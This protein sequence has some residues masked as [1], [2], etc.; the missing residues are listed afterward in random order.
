MRSPSR[1]AAVLASIALAWPVPGAGTRAE[2]GKPSKAADSKPVCR[3]CGGT[4]GL[5]PICVCEPGTKKKPKTSYSMRCEPVCVPAPSPWHGGGGLRH[6]PSCTG[7]PCD[8]GC[9]GAT[10]RTKKSLLKTIKEEEVDV[11]TRKIEHVCRHCSGR[12]TASSCTSCTDPGRP[13]SWLPWAWL[14]AR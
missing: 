11:V 5:E 12:E 10:V 4:C 2:A 8:G 9:G 14:F 1:I 7:G 6:A 13:R 3:V